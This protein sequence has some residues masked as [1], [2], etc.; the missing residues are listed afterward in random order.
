MNSSTTVSSSTIVL[1]ER[2]WRGSGL[3]FVLFFVIAYAISGGDRSPSLVAT[4]LFG[5]AILNLLWFAAAIRSTLSEAG[6]GGWGGAVTASSAAFASIYWVILAIGATVA[7]ASAG[8][9]NESF[10]S[11]LNDLVW[12]GIV[13]SSFPR[14][15]LIMAG[16]F[17]LWRAGIISNALFAVGV[18]AVILV[19]MGGTTWMSEGFWAPDGVYSRLIS[20]IIGIVW[21]SVASRFLL[22]QR[23]STQEGW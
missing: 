10:M 16:S 12:A 5:Y 22:T 19:L 17:G 4:F 9:G 8:S 11:G 6:Q 23:P 1:F 3:Q 21:I 13:I 20:P 14:A 2:L 7:Y 15:M 18:A